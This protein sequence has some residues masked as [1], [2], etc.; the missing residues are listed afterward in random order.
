MPLGSRSPNS[1]PSSPTSVHSSSC[2]SFKRDIEL[3]SP[4]SPPHLPANPSRAKASEQL[5]H[6]VPSV[7]DS[8]AA[9]LTSMDDTDGTGLGEVAVVE[10][11]SGTHVVLSTVRSKSTITTSTNDDTATASAGTTPAIITPTSAY[12]SATSSNYGDDLKSPTTTT[13]EHRPQP[14]PASTSPSSS[15][16]PPT[17][18]PLSPFVP[19]NI[20]HGEPPSPTHV[21]AK[22][23]SFMSYSDLLSSTPASTLTLSSL[24]TSA[25][26]SEPPPHIPSVSS[27]F[28][29]SSTAFGSS[30]NSPNSPSRHGG[31][32]PRQAGSATT[33]L[34]GFPI[35]PATGGL[36]HARKRDS[37]AMLDDVGGEREGLGM[38][39]EERLEVLIGAG[40]C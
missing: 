20:P 35:G 39:L 23:L 5:E 12:F 9:I 16:S 17:S 11:G 30:I 34:R 27:N 3:I 37:I 31:L 29:P 15:P 10:C 38:G 1:I 13:L 7:I 26:T 22:R 14:L 6:S 40:N 28:S 8:A 33:S 25:S 2:A 24:T 4:P 19:N 36:S 21:A 32:S 18:L